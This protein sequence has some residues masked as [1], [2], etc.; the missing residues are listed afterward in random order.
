MCCLWDLNPIFT[1]RREA[2]KG[3]GGVPW[4]SHPHGLRPI[5]RWL[6]AWILAIGLMPGGPLCIHCLPGL[7][8]TAYR[9]MY[10]RLHGM[11]TWISREDGM[12][13]MC[14]DIVQVPQTA[15]HTGTRSE[16]TWISIVD[17]MSEVCHDHPCHRLSPRS[18]S[19]HVI[20][21]EWV[22]LA[23]LSR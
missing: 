5:C 19:A 17:G 11:P 22:F 15:L 6:G 10:T 13:E 4:G 23:G 21:G 20:T 1:R 14:H 9:I 16:P 8:I 2:V 7:L 3:G 18:L 12:P